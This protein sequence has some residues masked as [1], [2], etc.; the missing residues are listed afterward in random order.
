MKTIDTLKNALKLGTVLGGLLLASAAVAEPASPDQA[1]VAP[2]SECA[3]DADCGEGKI[4]QL[5]SD[6]AVTCS[7]D[8]AGNEECSEE[9]GQTYGYCAQAPVT[10]VSDADCGPGLTCYLEGMAEP[11]PA[12]DCA[13]GEDC[14]GSTE[15]ANNNGL[16]APSGFCG[17]AYNSCASDADCGDNGQCLVVGETGCASSGGGASPGCAEGEDCPDEF[18]REE[19]PSE[20]CEGFVPEQITQCV[21]REITCAATSDCPDSW[22][23]EDLSYSECSGGGS[24]GDR[25]A[26]PCEEGEDCGSADPIQEPD[27]TEVVRF[28]CVPPGGGYVGIADSGAPRGDEEPLA[29]A[30]GESD[31]DGSPTFDGDSEGGEGSTDEEDAGN[32]SVSGIG[33]KASGAGGLGALLLGLVGLISRRRR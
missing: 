27:C 31:E 8:E 24:M 12:P 30:P 16:V 4:C 13:E 5:Y 18:P 6:G 29:N 20:D 22:T 28:L 33:G 2:E 26:P 9:T 11:L 19:E 23:C 15:P 32:C 1:L 25:E 7:I 10:C 3:T 17:W 14:G 21:P